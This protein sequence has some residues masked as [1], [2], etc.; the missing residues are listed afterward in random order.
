MALKVGRE[1]IMVLPV[2][3]LYFLEPPH[4]RNLL[5]KHTM[6][7]GIDAV[8]LDRGGAVTLFWEGRPP[9]RPPLDDIFGSR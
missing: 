1:W 7:L 5:R 4:A 2:E 3:G 6:Q 8:R 9:Q